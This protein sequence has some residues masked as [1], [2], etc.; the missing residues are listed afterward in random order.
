MATGQTKHYWCIRW[1]WPRGSL[2]WWHFYRDQT[3]IMFR[4]LGL[5]V[6]LLS[7]TENG[8]A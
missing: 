4:V 7:R 5:Q 2:R 6:I 1:R 3:L 8:N